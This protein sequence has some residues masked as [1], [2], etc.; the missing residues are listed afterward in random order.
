[1]G[2]RVEE[3]ERVRKSGKVA[4]A[5]RSARWEGKRIVGGGLP[6]T[7]AAGRYWVL[8]IQAEQQATARE[9]RDPGHPWDPGWAHTGQ[10]TFHS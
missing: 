1:M 9:G 3:C 6:K 5:G 2:E 4:A 7:A 8:P 10:V